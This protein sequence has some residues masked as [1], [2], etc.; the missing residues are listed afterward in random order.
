[1]IILMIDMKIPDINTVQT[2][3]YTN[4][5]P[6]NI[7][8]TDGDA[9]DWILAILEEDTIDFKHRRTTSLCQERWYCEMEEQSMISD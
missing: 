7:I 5:T 1:M 4:I 2:L 8:R 9:T 3:T 6:T